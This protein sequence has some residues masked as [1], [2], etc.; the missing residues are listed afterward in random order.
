ME[1]PIGDTVESA[2]PLVEA[3]ETAGV[4]VPTGHHRNDSPI[5]ARARETIRSGELGHPVAGAG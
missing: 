2:T 1:K 3:G 5:M 4:P